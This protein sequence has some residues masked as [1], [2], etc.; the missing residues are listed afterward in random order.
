[1]VFV[2]AG[3]EACRRS[4]LVLEV[5]G[6]RRAGPDPDVADAQEAAVHEG[7]RY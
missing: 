6:S 3:E 4:G 7:K 1:M 2:T 5:K